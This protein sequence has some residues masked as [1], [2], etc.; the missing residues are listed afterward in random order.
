MTAFGQEIGAELLFGK[1]EDMDAVAD[2]IV[3]HRMTV[4][5]TVM[6]LR[7]LAKRLRASSDET[8]RGRP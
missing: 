2:L 4:D 5:E 6:F 8:M 1:A 7:A 3:E